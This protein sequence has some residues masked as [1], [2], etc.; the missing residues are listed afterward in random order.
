LPESAIQ[1]SNKEQIIPERHYKMPILQ[2]KVENNGFVNK[3][4]FF[5]SKIS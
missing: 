5:F 4:K 1:C 3:F 2:E